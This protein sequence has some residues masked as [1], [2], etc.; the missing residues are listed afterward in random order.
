MLATTLVASFYGNM[1]AYKEVIQAGER[2]LR[3]G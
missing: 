3:A 2:M 1:L